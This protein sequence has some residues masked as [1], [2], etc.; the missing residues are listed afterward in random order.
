[1]VLLARPGTR[2]GTPA[3]TPV[4]G[5]TLSLVIGVTV[6]LSAGIPPLP[7]S[8]GQ[9][10]GR[11]L[12]PAI[13]PPVRTRVLPLTAGQA[14]VA[15]VS[16]GLFILL[17]TIS[18]AVIQVHQLGD[19][20]AASAAVSGAT[21]APGEERGDKLLV[22]VGRL[23]LEAL[24]HRLEPAFACTTGRGAGGLAS[25]GRTTTRHIMR[26]VEGDLNHGSRRRRADPVQEVRPLL[27]LLLLL[28]M[29]RITGQA[30]ERTVRPPPR[31][32]HRTL[33]RVQHLHFAVYNIFTPLCTTFSRCHLTITPLAHTVL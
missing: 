14:A 19:V 31:P 33:Y 26:R 11:D 29:S 10:G 20:C 24:H 16:P 4:V 27:L 15:A 23:V 21:A 30:G 6:P 8:A 25:P 2:R 13:I 17:T 7:A 3:S 18:A 32:P 1:M 28:L 22:V 12:G 9:S 5:V